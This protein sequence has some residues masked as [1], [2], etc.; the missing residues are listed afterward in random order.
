MATAR[1]ED[2]ILEALLNWVDCLRHWPDLPSSSE[3]ELHLRYPAVAGPLRGSL[4]GTEFWASDSGCEALRALLEDEEL[5]ALYDSDS[6]ASMSELRGR[7]AALVSEALTRDDAAQHLR[8]NLALLLAECRK[9]TCTGVSLWLVRGL[10]VGTELRIA[11]SVFVLPASDEAMREFNERSKAGGAMVPSDASAILVAY[12]SASR[13]E[14]G[15]FAGMSSVAAAHMVLHSLS[16]AIWLVTG[17]FPVPVITIGAEVARFPAV[18][19]LEDQ[20]SFVERGRDHDNGDVRSDQV[21]PIRA[22]LLRLWN[23]DWMYGPDPLDAGTVM[24]VES[25]LRLLD[26][27][28]PSPD[29][30]VS[31]LACYAAIDGLMS[32]RKESDAATVPRVASLLTRDY[33]RRRSGRRLIQR[34]YELRGEMAHGRRPEPEVIASA[35][36]IGFDPNVFRQPSFNDELRLTSL[37]LARVVTAF[38]LEN[39]VSIEDASDGTL[40][41]AKLSK[42]LPISKLRD[43]LQSSSQG[44]ASSSERVEAMMPSWLRTTA[45]ELCY[46]RKKEG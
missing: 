12:G 5:A 41:P 24:A 27:A 33:K 11:D 16:R 7:V 39:I 15:P 25:A 37:R 17:Y 2:K 30:L 10:T 13:D 40:I 1:V 21:Q 14:M 45:E 19:T 31:N 20:S 29:G 42:G 8:S 6:P 18:A 22:M 9:T 36:G 3:L 34:L 4:R 46:D 23:R 35:L 44:D 43:V 28:L 32:G 38:V 26:G